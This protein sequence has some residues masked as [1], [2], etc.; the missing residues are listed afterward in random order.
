VCTLVP[1]ASK[2]VHI[3]L[4]F[5]ASEI[6]PPTGPDIAAPEPPAPDPCGDGG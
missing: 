5:D 4:G 6:A 1:G 3:G 2:Q